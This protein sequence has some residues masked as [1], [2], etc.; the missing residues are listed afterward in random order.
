[1]LAR[2]MRGNHTLTSLDL[3]ENKIGDEGCAALGEALGVNRGLRCLVLW[4][5]DIGG[6]GISGLATG[7]AAN[8]SLQILDMGDNRVDEA[9]SA[10]P[11]I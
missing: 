2:L 1:M 7:L 5:N 6:A 9:V 8:S 3:R 10:A 11:T 4:S